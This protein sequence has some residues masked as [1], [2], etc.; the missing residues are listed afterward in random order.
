MTTSTSKSELSAATSEDLLHDPQQWGPML[1][2]PCEL[3]L[4]LAV[5][6]F[7]VSDL[8]RLQEG[9]LLNTRW[10]QGEDVPL[11]INDQLVAWAEFEALDGSLGMRITEWA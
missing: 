1:E 6:D 4:E 8:L 2:L 5:P 3:T 11:R 7:T 10:S 9:D